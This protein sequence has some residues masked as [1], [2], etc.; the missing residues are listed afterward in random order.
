MENHNE[1]G[2]TYNISEETKR[3]S[4]FTNCCYE[5]ILSERE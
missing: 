5:E 4:S 3:Y 1:K 2:L